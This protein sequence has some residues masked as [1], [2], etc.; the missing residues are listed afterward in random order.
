MRCGVSFFSPLRELTTAIEEID[1]GNTKYRIPAKATSYEFDQLNRQFNRSIEAVANAE[2]KAYTSQLESERIRIRYLTQQMQ[3]HFVLNT[4]NL[5][6]SMEPDQYPLMI[7]TLLCLSRYFRYVAHIS[8][9][10]VPVEAELEHVKN[11]FQLQQIR[12][13]D[14]FTY[15]IQC[16]EEL[17]EMLI[18]P[19][20]IQTFAENA[21]KHSLVIGMVNHV[22][23]RIEMAKEQLHISIHDT[24][25]GYPDDV[26][27]KIRL[28]Q[29]TRVR[30]EGLGAGHPEYHRAPG[31]AL[32]TQCRAFLLQCSQ[33]RRAGGY[34]F[35]RGT[36]QTGCKKDVM[37]RKFVVIILLYLQ[38]ALHYNKAI[39]NPKKGW[40]P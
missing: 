20:V 10:L 36:Q 26:L 2:A 3:P 19:I 13:P 1:R 14:N 28:F 17:L 18:P 34:L 7:K 22:K 12:Y 6:Y 16:P 25:T 8:E 11:Y 29:Q 33:G 31:T 38:S 35:A 27:E 40:Q 5:V 9:P 30:Q 4:L 37:N 23:V 24:G 15:D 21:I 32:R 39:N